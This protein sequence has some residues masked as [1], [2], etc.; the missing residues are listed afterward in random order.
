MLQLWETVTIEKYKVAI[1]KQIHSC[2]EK[3]TKI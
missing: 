2:E 1:E 3:I